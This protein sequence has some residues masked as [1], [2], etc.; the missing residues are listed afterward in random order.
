TLP[1][2]L[3]KR[4]LDVRLVALTMHAEVAIVRRV[5]AAGFQGYVLKDNSFEELLDALRTVAAGDVFVSPALELQLRREP[6]FSS[7]SE[8]EQTVL[9]WIAD[10]S[11]TKRIAAELGISAKTV[12][13]Y[14][15][16]LMRKL[17][18]RSSAELVRRAIE[19]GLLPT[20]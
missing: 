6:E 8:R 9:R 5:L 18:V 7:L 17:E 2:R 19:L 14:R 16:R 4:G 11:T 13:T 20:S 1:V 12:E 15:M 3:S 10:G